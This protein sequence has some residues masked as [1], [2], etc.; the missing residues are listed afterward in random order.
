MAVHAFSLPPSA[1]APPAFPD[2]LG[3]PDNDPFFSVEEAPSWIT[4]SGYQFHA[5]HDDSEISSR[6][7]P[8]TY[9]RLNS[10][11]PACAECRL[12]ASAPSIEQLNVMAAIKWPL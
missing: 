12:I 2:T 8:I 7:A 9:E 1:S 6:W 10:D 4:P 5:L 11:R 3:D